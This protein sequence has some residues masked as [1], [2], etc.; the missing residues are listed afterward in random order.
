M[1]SHQ[2]RVLILAYPDKRDPYLRFNFGYKE[3]KTIILESEK[4]VTVE[5]FDMSKSQIEARDSL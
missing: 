1:E 4:E 5:L 3:H 2:F